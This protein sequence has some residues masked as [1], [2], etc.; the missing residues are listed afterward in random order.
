MS[1]V[2]H[3]SIQRTAEQFFVLVEHGDDD[4]E[5]SFP[6]H[7]ILTEG[8]VLFAEVVGIAGDGGVSGGRKGVSTFFRSHSPRLRA[9]TLSSSFLALP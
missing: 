6:S 2:L 1:N 3:H 5:L 8:E 9:L 7:R 4:G